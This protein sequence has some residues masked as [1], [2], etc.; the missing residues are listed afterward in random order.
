MGYQK[1][2]KEGEGAKI[3]KNAIGQL[4]RDVFYAGTFVWGDS[5]VDLAEKNPYYKPMITRDELFRL[6][7]MLQ[8]KAKHTPD[9]KKKK[10]QEIR[11]FNDDT[12]IN[13]ET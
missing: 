4:W 8:G 11:P 3:S 5:E 7:L 13:A 1:K 6:N 12:L 10:Y 9:E 2:G